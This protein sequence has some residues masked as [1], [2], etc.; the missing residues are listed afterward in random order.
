MLTLFVASAYC[1]MV[2]KKMMD[3]VK[4]DL[5]MADCWGE[6]ASHTYYMSVV[7]AVKHCEQEDAIFS[8]SEFFPQSVVS[9]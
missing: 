1:G 8:V 3:M 2:D 9:N 4:N 6:E 5:L 7:K